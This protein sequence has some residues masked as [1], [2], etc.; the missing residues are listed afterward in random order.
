MMNKYLFIGLIVIIGGLVIITAISRPLLIGI[1]LIGVWVYLLWMIQKKKTKIFSE[2]VEAKLAERR[3]KKLKVFLL[4]AGISLAV[5]I[6]GIITHGVLGITLEIEEEVVSFIIALVG[7][8]MFIASTIAG[9]SIF[10]TGRLKT[11]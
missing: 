9:L 6:V 2:K 11:S 7:I 8:W 3:L 10:L 1:P 5:G 4:V